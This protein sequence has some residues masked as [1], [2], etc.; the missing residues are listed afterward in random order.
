MKNIFIVAA[1][2]VL[3]AACQRAT[4]PVKTPIVNTEIKKESGQVVLLGH[5]SHSILQQP[6]YKTW[7]DKSYDA[8]TVDTPAAKQ[9]QHGLQNRSMEI[10]LG[11]WCGD[12][13]REVPRMLKVL[14]EAGMDTTNISL[15]FV[16]NS[17][18]TY[19]QSPQHEE[20]NRN[21]HRVPTFIIYDGGKELG[22]IV[23]SP[24]VS[25]EKDMLAILGHQSYTP[26]YKA[27]SYW[28][29]HDK[30]RNTSLSDAELQN[31]VPEL[32][33]LCK[34]SG[35]FNTY[36]YVLLAAGKN[37]QALNVFRLNTLIYPDTASVF[38]SLGEALAKTGD[39][40][41]AITA[42]EKVLQLRPADE[43]ARKMLAGLRN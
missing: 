33:P 42:Y 29:S 32:K 25:L 39:K 23:E 24:V 34:Y 37:V 13:K 41:A 6:E 8:Y 9:L 2:L 27:V 1:I 19:K 40:P 38:D 28:I 43:N 7:F 30:A 20:K 26:N 35:E 21:I 12:S 4:V 14:Q 17:L 18:Q 5:A 22:R 16:D 10:F 3:A 15:V 36:G 31:L 11:S